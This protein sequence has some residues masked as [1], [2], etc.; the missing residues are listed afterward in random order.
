MKSEPIEEHLVYSGRVKVRWRNVYQNYA[1][2]RERMP[3][4][5][6]REYPALSLPSPLA[7][8]SSCPDGGPVSTSTVCAHT[9]MYI[10][11]SRALTVWRSP[12]C[13]K[14]QRTIRE[15]DGHH[16]CCKTWR[17]S[18]QLFYAATDCLLGNRPYDTVKLQSCIS[19]VP[20]LN[21]LTI[22]LRKQWQ[23]G[24]T[25]Y[26]QQVPLIVPDMNDLIS[27][28]KHPVCQVSVSFHK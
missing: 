23:D 17:T 11:T 15:Q 19:T 9:H 1:A 2:K 18:I 14:G 4:P 22:Q 6:M 20:V 3:R 27:S 12:L 26:N 24:L 28:S 7:R 21:E 25:C 10:H 5:R 8:S 13:F 16:V